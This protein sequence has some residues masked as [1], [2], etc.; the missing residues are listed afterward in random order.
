MR[1]ARSAESQG[2]LRPAFG[3]SRACGP[4]R[5]VAPALRGRRNSHIGRWVRW[6]PAG[7]PGCRGEV[8]SGLLITWSAVVNAT[9]AGSPRTG[10]ALA[11]NLSVRIGDVQRA[12]AFTVCEGV[13]A[14]RTSKPPR[15]CRRFAP[16]TAQGAPSSWTPDGRIMD[17]ATAQARDR[18]HDTP[19][20]SLQNAEADAGTRTPDPFIT[21]DTSARNERSRKATPGHEYLASTGKGEWTIV[22]AR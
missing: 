15:F 4:H 10:I 9:S 3:S 1:C 7:G 6:S 11:R 16:R 5:R 2:S 20:K 18:W 22:N 19:T 8:A 13:R 12:G 21:S 17:A 14:A